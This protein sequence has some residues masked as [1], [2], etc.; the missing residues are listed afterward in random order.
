VRDCRRPPPPPPP[1]LPPC[2]SA[3]S[4]RA[5]RRAAGAPDPRG[6]F[7]FRGGEEEG[8]ARLRT[9]IW[10]SPQGG[11]AGPP[12]GA[13]ALRYF[14]DTRCRAL[15]PPLAS[16]AAPACSPPA[17]WHG[18]LAIPANR[19]RPRCWPQ[20]AG[21]GRGQQHQAQPLPGGGL[22]VAAHGAGGAAAA[23]GGSAA[24]RRARGRVRLAAHAPLHPRLLHVHRAQGGRARDERRR[25]QGT[26]AAVG[27]RAGHLCQV[28]AAPRQGCCL[29]SLLAA[30]RPAG[31]ASALPG[32][33]PR[34]R[35]GRDPCQRLLSCA[36]AA[37]GRQAA[38]ACPLWTRACA[39]WR[40]PAT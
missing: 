18:A 11:A 32:R 23:A 9:Y 1:L 10:G 7:P 17:R 14:T 8:V 22:P 28:R 12:G 33:L 2:T 39:S 3:A 26:G 16:C 6:A 40:A 27:Q 34:R 30:R 38:R 37:G 13:A 20:D 21:G 31:R 36:A 15:P 24:A 25:H 5:G 19:R 29:A 4:T 35:A